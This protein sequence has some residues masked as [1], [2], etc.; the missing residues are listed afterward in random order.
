MMI[1][2]LINTR[3]SHHLKER[4]L[5]RVMSQAKTCLSSRMLKAHTFPV[6][7]C[8][9]YPPTPADARGSALGNKTFEPWFGQ[10]HFCAAAAAA[11]KS[12]L[13]WIR[14]LVGL[15]DKRGF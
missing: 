14:F 7:F 13:D 9:P 3:S 8:I 4:S 10:Q 5:Q 6:R 12:G 15:Q 1:R 2:P 11:I